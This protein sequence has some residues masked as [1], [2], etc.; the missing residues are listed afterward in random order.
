MGANNITNVG[1]IGFNNTATGG[2]NGTV[3]NDSAAAGKVGEA[4][5]AVVT[6]FTNFAATAT[7]GNV[8]SISLTAGDWD[9]TG[10]LYYQL[11]G[12]TSAGAYEVAISLFS[13]NT[14]TDHSAGDNVMDGP[15]P[16]VALNQSISVPVWRVSVAST[17]TVFLKALGVYT[18]GNPRYVGRISAR[19]IR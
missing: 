6:S 16:T 9:V 3:T 14:T 2:I 15:F 10:L 12:A 7:W 17:T 18:V 4:V 1:S 13:G 11:N 5:R 19:R 8:T